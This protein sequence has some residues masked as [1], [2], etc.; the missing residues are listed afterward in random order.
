MVHCLLLG[1]TPC[2]PDMPS[3]VKLGKGTPSPT[4]R[5]PYV[6]ASTDTRS[7]PL[8]SCYLELAPKQ[9]G[10][11]QRCVALSQ[12]LMQRCRCANTAKK[13]KQTPSSPTP[14]S[15]CLVLALGPC[16]SPGG[17]TRC[18]PAA[19]HAVSS[20]GSTRLLPG[21]QKCPFPVAAAPRV[22]QSRRVGGGGGTD[23]PQHSALAPRVGSGPHP[24]LS[25]PGPTA[26]SPPWPHAAQLARG[27]PPAAT[28][29]ART[30][31]I[32]PASQAWGAKCSP[33]PRL[34]NSHLGTWGT[35]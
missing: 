20:F 6:H 30:P 1:S 15:A 2:P 22:R 3:W 10:S 23:H 5:L 29:P 31:R 24:G 17:G 34:P 28:A 16:A 18:D 4:H 7:A 35:W 25:P 32:A 12:D 19:T 9:L 33:E 27:K 13:P 11:S 8:T 14:P 21:E 26:A